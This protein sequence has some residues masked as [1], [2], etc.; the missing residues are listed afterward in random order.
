[1]STDD[2]NRPLKRRSRQF[3]NKP[4]PPAPQGGESEPRS[5]SSLSPP[6]PEE[7]RFS[8]P[9]PRPPAS[10][11]RSDK[12]PPRP[13]PP[14]FTPHECSKPL[15]KPPRKEPLHSQKDQREKRKDG[16]GQD[17]RKPEKKKKK[18]AVVA[19]GTTLRDFTGADGAPGYFQQDLHVYG[20]AG[21]SCRRCTSTLRLT[22]IT[23]R[24]STWCPRC[25]PR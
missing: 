8:K 12:P 6:P 2:A 11:Q 15:P 14:T 10:A 16:K 21:L 18:R 17:E 4:L 19:G 25:Q 22:R 24:S 3:P 7:F 1:M 13:P 9:L 5:V 23:G 20:R